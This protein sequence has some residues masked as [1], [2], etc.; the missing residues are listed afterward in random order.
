MSAPNK[1]ADP[2]AAAGVDIAAGNRL[3][4]RIA[5]LAAPTHGALPPGARV[6]GGIG[7]FA[8]S[9]AL[10]PGMRQ[11]VLV[12]ATDGVGTKLELARAHNAPQSIG[13]DVVAMCVNDILCTGARPLFFLDYIACGKLDEDFICAVV[14]ALAAACRECGCALIGGETAEMP[15]VYEDSGF[16]IA[17]FAVGVAEQE[18]L[19]TPSA[20]TG[21]KLIAIASGGAHSNGYSLIR[22]LL[23]EQPA[24]QQQQI[25]G[26]SLLTAL[27]APTRLYVR[28]VDALRGA[29]HLRGLAHITGG[30][31][32]ENLPRAL[33]P[34][35]AG[36]LEPWQMPPL[37]TALQKAGDIDTADMQRIFNC[38]VGMVAVVAAD[39]LAPALQALTAAGEQAWLLGTVAEVAE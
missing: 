32:S 2:Y 19:L 5:S 35:L 8:A 14:S 28:A 12:S 23:A 18:E 33:P 31:I 6:I 7:G 30:G 9:V 3:V 16:D 10:P 38:G 26:Q 37:F 36:H 1:P 22:R 17:G 25:D 34:G 20:V 11:P 29:V 13:I 15:G 27:L 21:D 39:E 24:L 4:R